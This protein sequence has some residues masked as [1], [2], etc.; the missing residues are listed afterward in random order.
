MNR[1][2]I[3]KRVQSPSV[4]TGETKNVV[5][6]KPLLKDISTSRVKRANL[7]MRM[8]MGIRRSARVTSGFSKKIESQM[9]AARLHLMHYN[10]G[11]MNQ[12][13]RATPTR[14]AG[15]AAYI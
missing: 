12:P 15:F 2:P 10:F 6:G 1:P 9:F 4:V 5:I 8:G 3:E 11:R 14:Q 13:L 7:P